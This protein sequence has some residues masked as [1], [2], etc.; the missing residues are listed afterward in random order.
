MSP[1]ADVLH[2]LPTPEVH[3]AVV[4]QRDLLSSLISGLSQGRGP[5]KAGRRGA[6][7]PPHPFPCYEGSR[8][9]ERGAAV[10]RE[11]RHSADG[12]GPQPG[13]CRDPSGGR[14]WQPLQGLPSSGGGH[15]CGVA[16][17]SG[18]SPMQVHSAPCPACRQPWI[19]LSPVQAVG[20]HQGKHITHGQ[21]FSMAFSWSWTKFHLGTGP[22]AGER[23]R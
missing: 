11:G 5:G 12:K 6:V 23:P 17:Q 15:T 18:G 20:Q 2:R 7:P 14:E 21:G 1:P 16:G 10:G 19:T 9:V 4:T 8:G 22:R 3:P 13:A